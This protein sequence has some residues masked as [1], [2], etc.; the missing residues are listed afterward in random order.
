MGAVQQA[1]LMVGGGAA[2]LAWSVA[3]RN[4]AWSL[5]GSN[6]TASLTSATAAEVEGDIA[7]S[8]GKWYFEVLVGGTPD[9]G[10]PHSPGIGVIAQGT[11]SP[12]WITLG[13]ASATAWSYL[14]SA[15]KRNN[16]SASAYGATYGAGDVIQVWVDFA[17]GIWWGKND[18]VQGGGDPVAGTGAA[19]TGLSGT[20][21]PH[22]AANAGTPAGTIRASAASCAYSPR[23]GFSYW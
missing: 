14:R 2:E 3:N 19:Y 17:V 6:R 4:S 16:G 13:G 15:L 23:S 18:T 21:V 8:T 12:T 9:T 10:L 1:L 22:M 11:G 20:L 7:H 5:S